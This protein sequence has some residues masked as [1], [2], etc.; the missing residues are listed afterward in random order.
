MGEL[1]TAL[2]TLRLRMHF[3]RDQ[4]HQLAI[5]G[6]AEGSGSGRSSRNSHE[7]GSSAGSAAA[8]TDE[9]NEEAYVPF[10]G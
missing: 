1:E 6:P 4:L 7:G 10:L 3:V 2:S 9:E 8:Q 5:A